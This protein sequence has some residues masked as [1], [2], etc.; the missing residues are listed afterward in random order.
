MKTFKRIVKKLT[1]E[2]KSIATMESCTGGAVA[3]AI[4]NIEG[5]SDVYSYSA[6]T[7]SNS[8]KIKMGVSKEII[9]TYTVYS[10]ETAR[11]MAHAITTFSGAELGVGITGKLNRIDK[12]NPYGE[13]NVVF[14]AI[15]DKTKDKYWE[16]QVQAKEGSRKKNK[17]FIIQEII[18]ILEEN[19]L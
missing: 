1:E 14:V 19:V 6:I 15:Y 5:A 17:E 3:N 13:D 11:E 10:K 7:Y 12:N 4:T 8:F 9:D 18:E 16:R 2:K